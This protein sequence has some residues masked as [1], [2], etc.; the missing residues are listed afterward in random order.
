LGAGNWVTSEAPIGM[1]VDPS[2]VEGMHP[3]CIWSK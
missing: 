3:Q 2:K 1:V